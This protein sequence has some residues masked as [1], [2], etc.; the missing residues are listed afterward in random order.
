L[1]QLLQRPFLLHGY[2]PETFAAATF[3]P[4]MTQIFAKDFASSSRAYSR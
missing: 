2:S 1:L 4:R 3:C